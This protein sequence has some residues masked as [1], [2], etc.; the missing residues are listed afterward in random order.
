MKYYIEKIDSF[1]EEKR[2]EFLSFLDKEKKREFMSASNENRKLSILISQGFAKE[3]ISEE[4]NIPKSE[5]IFS[6]SDRGKPYCKSHPHIYFSLSHSG[7]F[8]ALAISDK[9][10]GIDIEK[11]RPAKDNLINRVCSQNE[12]DAISNS[13]NPH[14]KFTEIWTKK[15]AYLKAL[16]TGIDRELTSI[17]TTDKNL[18]FTTEVTD[19]FIVSVFS[20]SL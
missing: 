19:E 13:E 18:N 2:E 7:N 20:F 9:E 8:V 3:K 15:E 11:L 12:I 4:Y 17:D 14:I 1:S 16:G 10:V 5:I 6:V